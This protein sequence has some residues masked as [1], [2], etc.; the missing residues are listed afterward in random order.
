MTQAASRRLESIQLMT[1]VAFQGIDS[2]PT[3]DSSRSPGIHLDQIMTQV[4]ALGI[5]SNWLMTQN[6]SPLFNLN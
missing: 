5:K 6:A 3:H 2:E 1:Q 4:A